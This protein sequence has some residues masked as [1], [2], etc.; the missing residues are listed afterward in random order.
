METKMATIVTKS[1]TRF[2]R[3]DT[4]NAATNED[5]YSAGDIVY[6]QDDGLLIHN[7]TNFEG[8]EAKFKGMVIDSGIVEKLTHLGD[9]HATQEDY[10]C[11]VSQVFFNQST[12]AN[13]TVNLINFSLGLHSATNVVVIVQ[14]DANPY[15]PSA[16]VISSTN[17]R[18][19]GSSQ[20]IHWAGGSAPVPTANGID[21]FSFTVFK[22]GNSG[23]NYVLGQLVPFKS[24]S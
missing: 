7:G 3:I 8:I 12:G 18:A 14:Q 13:W 11:A 20:T 2:K 15:Y 23:V 16:L 22:L 6:D 9:A 24:I 1:E 10:D 5:D 17:N 19:D 21:V 4:D